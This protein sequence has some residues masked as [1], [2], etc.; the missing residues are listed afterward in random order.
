[1]TISLAMSALMLAGKL[2]AYAITHSSAML[3]DAAESVV[4]GVA[5]AFAAFSLWYAAKPADTCH[6]YGHGRI[7]Y[8]STG[9]EGALVLAASMAVIYSGIEG[10]IRGPQ[11]ERL[12]AGLIISGG[13]AL[14]NLVLGIALVT[15][16]RRQNAVVLVANGQ[17]VLSDFWTTAGAIIGVGLVMLTGISWFDPV[18]ALLLGVWIML[19]GI[20]MIRRSIAGLM[21][22]VSPAQSQQL[23]EQLREHVRDG[24]IVDFH[25]LRSRRVNDEIWIDVHMLVPGE[26]PLATAHDRVTT[27]E[28]KIREM[29]PQTTVHIATHIEPA[30]HESAHPGGHQ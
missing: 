22:A 4:H 20:G 29:F 15:I 10:L 24:D 21:D 16:G 5:T 27:V 28:E 30:D 14:I 18:A 1:M 11:L 26:V 8:F 13:L 3:A 2:T 19:S 12:G 7:V 23:T 9:F 25:Q 17:H 6:P